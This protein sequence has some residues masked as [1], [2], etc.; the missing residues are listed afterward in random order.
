MHDKYIEWKRLFLFLI[1]VT[2]TSLLHNWV[3]YATCC[4]A[5]EIT[6]ANC[7]IKYLF[8]WLLLCKNRFV[9][10]RVTLRSYIPV[11]A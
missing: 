11:H 4:H 9:L 8:V 1:M 6:C 3:V 7:Y 10:V 5:K 2:L